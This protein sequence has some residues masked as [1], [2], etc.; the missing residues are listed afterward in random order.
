MTGTMEILDHTGDTKVIWDKDN[1]DEVEAARAQFD[2]LVGSKR[3]AAFEVKGE[4][5]DKG[6]QIRAFDPNAER[7][8]LVPPMVGG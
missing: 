6:K 5:G 2:K 8:I 7:M 4:K 1:P 3:F